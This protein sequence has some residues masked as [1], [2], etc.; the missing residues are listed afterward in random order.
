MKTPL[1]DIHYI[2]PPLDRLPKLDRLILQRN[3]FVIHAPRQVGKIISMMAL[4]QQL[5]SSGQYIPSL[6]CRINLTYW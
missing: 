1:N 3:Y 5:T 4:A 6:A 2:L